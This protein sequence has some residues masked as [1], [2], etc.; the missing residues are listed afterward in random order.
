MTEGSTNRKPFVLPELQHLTNNVWCFNFCR[1]LNS[2]ANN[3]FLNTD[4]M[5]P[6]RDASR[7][8]S[9]SR[10]AGWTT[11]GQSTHSETMVGLEHTSVPGDSESE[12]RCELLREHM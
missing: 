8:S 12:L 11:V 1:F 2:N 7:R 4:T 6:F 10:T 9:W 3:I 5:E